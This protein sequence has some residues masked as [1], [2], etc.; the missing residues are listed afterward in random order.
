[1]EANFK[2]EK[3]SN[4][5]HFA[6]DRMEYKNQR[7]KYIAEAV[8]K[9]LREFIGGIGTNSKDALMKILYEKVKDELSA[10]IGGQKL[11]REEWPEEKIFEIINKYLGIGSLSY[12]LEVLLLRLSAKVDNKPN[13]E[14]GVGY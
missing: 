11:N 9:V 4:Q 7:D 5:K 13:S 10:G 8:Q 3:K 6:M 12:D 1:M 14:S 2:V